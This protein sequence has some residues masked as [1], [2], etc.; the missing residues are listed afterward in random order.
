MKP[1]FGS[2]VPEI[3][4]DPEPIVKEYLFRF[5]MT[6]PMP[7]IALPFV[8]VIP[9]KA[10]DPFKFNHPIQSPSV[11][12]PHVRNLLTASNPAINPLSL[13]TIRST[14]AR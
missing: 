9:L 7:V 3:I 8:A 10:D 11:L 1:S 14:V 4:A 12:M 13:N 2:A 5:G 6:D